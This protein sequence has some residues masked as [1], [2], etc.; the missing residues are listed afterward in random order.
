MVLSVAGF[1]LMVDKPVHLIREDKETNFIDEGNIQD[2]YT[3]ISSGSWNTPPKILNLISDPPNGRPENYEIK[4][5]AK[6]AF[7]S[8]KWLDHEE[9]ELSIS[10]LKIENISGG[11]GLTVVIKNEGDIDVSDITLSID[12]T[13]GFIV[14]LPTKYYYIP[15]LPSAKSTEIRIKIF[16]IGLGIF[17]EI[18]KITITASAPATNTEERRFVVKILGPLVKTVR[19]FWNENDSFDGYTLFAPEISKVTY[20]INNSGEVIHTWNSNYQIVRS[21]YLLES[22]NILRT[23]FPGP[24]PPFWGG[25][26]G[27]RVEEIDF[28]G[29]VVWEFEYSTDLHCLHHDIEALSNGNVLMA[30]WEYKTVAE[31]IAA[32]RDPKKLPAGQ[33]WPDHI[34]EVEPT[35]TAGGNIVWEWHVWDHLIQDY[36][37]TKEN[38][39]VVEDHPELFDINFG[40]Q[41]SGDW[42]HINSID[43]NE[44]F[45]QIILSSAAHSEIWVIDHSTTT[46]EAAGHTGGSSRKGGDILYRWGNPQAYRAGNTDDRKLFFQHDAQWIESGHPG[47]GNILIFNNGLGRPGGK[48]SSIE[49]I[50]PPV[51]SNGNYSLTSGS[52]YEPE[53]PIWTYTAENPTD[54]YASVIS[55][56]QR[57]PNGNTLICN[58][59]FGIFFEVTSEKEIVWEYVNPFPNPN[60]NRVFKIRRYAPDYPGIENLLDGQPP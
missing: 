23:C 43:Y 58:G 26:I 34:I 10:T 12:A 14:I 24:N 45:D 7:N 19:E 25:G 31:A 47:E 49:E 15:L 16:G 35:G 57:F 22:G 17:T 46:E 30:A 21:V 39:G 36:D 51:D 8:N 33:I 50:V 55:G 59:P 37:P 53:E 28:N 5:N 29:T 32:G 54:F 3:F 27:G 52:P 38:Y 18:P 41:L 44:E 42:N 9:I 6:N 13:G 48:Y 56:V 4:V 60:M 1:E 11:L 20:L 40:G 2:R